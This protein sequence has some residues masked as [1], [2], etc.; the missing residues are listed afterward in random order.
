M[1]I[2]ITSRDRV[3]LA[4]RKLSAAEAHAVI[5]DPFAVIDV[6]T[7]EIILQ[8]RELNGTTRMVAYD[9]ESDTLFIKEEPADAATT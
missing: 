6:G 2:L 7:R 4:T 5:H 8:P 1:K 3:A 9:Q